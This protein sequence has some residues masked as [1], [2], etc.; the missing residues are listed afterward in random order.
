MDF[1][2]SEE[3]A[4]LRDTL[5][6]YLADHY[7]FETRRAVIATESGW[8]PQ[9]WRALA[10]DL[11]LFGAAFPETLGGLGGNAIEHSIVME[12]FGKVL[13]VEP[14]LGT[15]VIGGG[16]FKHSGGA[17]AVEFVPRIIAGEVLLAFAH[18]EPQ[19]RYNLVDLKT[20]ATHRNGDYILNGR[21][22]VVIGAPWATHLIVSVRS[23]GAQRD[24]D[25]ITLLLV[26]KGAKGIRTQN[27]PT[28][29]GGRAAEIFFDNVI[30]PARHVIGEA[31]KA[32]P[33]IERV[34]DEAICALCAEA[35]GGMRRMLADTV[36]YASQRKQFGV[37]I[38]SFQVLQH[39]V[40][41]M[42]TALEQSAA[43]TQVATMK[44][45][46]SA[47]ERA[48]AASAAKVQIGNAGKFIGQAAIQI[49][50]G[51]GITEELALGHYFKRITAI[52]N[53]F[54]STDHHLRHYA[55]LSLATAA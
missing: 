38:A 13:V 5:A 43:L 46:A 19:A 34:V 29:D 23:N 32:L 21:K 45:E 12:E 42:F 35:V 48:L 7:D 1:N 40:A 6:S 55:D 8:R 47:A 17:L 27:Y 28:I 30:V 31:G 37:P 25:G 50:G 14:Y 44:I 24:R 49:H 16:L 3:Q 33:L 36:N 20:T 9:V 22:S 51:M 39:R 2:F 15:L 53:Q 4:L 26:D 10:K 52:G 54:G 41:D 18:A 11:D